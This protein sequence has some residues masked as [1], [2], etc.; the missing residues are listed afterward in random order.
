VIGSIAP[1]SD[2][3]VGTPHPIE[4]RAIADDG[5]W[6]V[7]CQARVDHDGDGVIATYIGPYRETRGDFMTP[8]LVRGS[9]AGESIDTLVAFTNDWLAVIRDARLEL[10]EAK[11]GRATVLRDA[12]L[13]NDHG[14]FGDGRQ[15]SI[16]ANGTR[17]TYLRSDGKHEQV[18]I[19]D[20]RTGAERVAEPGATVWRTEVDEGG[21]WARVSIVRDD[22]NGDGE[23]TFGSS[24]RESCNSFPRP[25]GGPR[26]DEPVDLWLDLERGA[27]VED[28]AIMRALGPHLLR[29]MPDGSLRFDDDE[30]APA[31]CNARFTWVMLDPP[32]VI[33]TC[34]RANETGD[35]PL[36]IFG[37]GLALRPGILESR[38][39][40]HP[41]IGVLDDRLRCDRTA[42]IELA[43]GANV[44]LPQGTLE[45][46]HE[47]RVMLRR[48]EQRIGYDVDTGREV[49]LPDGRLWAAGRGWVMFDEIE[50]VDITTGREVRYGEHEVPVGF[51]RG[52]ALI[53]KRG[54]PGPA[55]PRRKQPFDCD[56]REPGKPLPRGPLRWVRP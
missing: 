41:Y 53:A 23:V 33:A 51:A 56:D 47:N 26:D 6:I 15:A 43:T 36:V 4:V 5:S 45:Y 1:A 34:G 2:P 22:S 35:V 30:I 19:R 25:H 31:S 42:C 40:Q 24:P 54:T 21:R 28:P 52:K 14:Q 17:M 49:A 7:I 29:V 44:R 9:G 12:D 3:E 20:L 18:V 48:G 10:I 38:G 11:T 8:Y 39:G 37:K 50:L 27:F 13:R 16:A 32:R 46:P 55:C